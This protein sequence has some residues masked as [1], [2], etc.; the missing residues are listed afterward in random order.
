LTSYVEDALFPASTDAVI[1][2][3]SLM[4]LAALETVSGA[5]VAAKPL[6]M[7]ASKLAFR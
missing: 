1:E 7:P 4:F 5:K 3:G 2:A 6:N